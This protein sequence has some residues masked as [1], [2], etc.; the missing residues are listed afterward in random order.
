[1]IGM[2]WFALNLVL[3]WIVLLPMS[4][5]TIGEHFQDIGLRYLLIPMIAVAIGYVAERAR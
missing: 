5:Q 2:Y 4:G 1:M 3:D